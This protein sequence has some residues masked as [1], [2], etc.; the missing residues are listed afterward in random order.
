MKD[1]NNTKITATNFQIPPGWE[2]DKNDV[3]F[4]D[5]RAMTYSEFLAWCNTPISIN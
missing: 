2:G 4:A 3:F 5:G 1:D